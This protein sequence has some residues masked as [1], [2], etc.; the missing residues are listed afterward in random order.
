M[1]DHNDAKL[2]FLSEVIQ[3]ELF[4]KGQANIIIAPC[5]SGKTTAAVTKIAALASA[6]EKV[7]FL[8]DTTAGKQA[9]LTRQETAR[10]TQ[11]WLEEIKDEWWGELFSGNGIRVMSYHQL[12]YQLQKHPDFLK[13]IEVVVCDEMHNLIKFLNIERA[14]N[15]QSIQDGYGPEG[16]PCEIALAE[17][18]RISAKL[19]D[20]PLVVIITAT[21]NAVSKVLDS[22]NVPVEYFDYTEAAYSDRTGEVVYYDKLAEVLDKLDAQRAIIYVPTINGMKE[23]AKNADDGWRNICCLWGLHNVDHTMSDAQLKVRNT[24]LEIRRIPDDIDLLFINAAYETSINIDNEDF[25]TVIVHSSNPDVQTQVRER[26]RHDIDVLYLH[27]SEHEHVR[28]YFPEEYLNKFLTVKETRAIAEKMNLHNSKG[29][30]L[31]WPSV[32]DKLANDG[33]IIDYVKQHGV[34]GYIIRKRL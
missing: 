15:K 19:E 8:I 34:R 20:V 14:R 22:R 33:Y 13:N 2:P 18:C 26:L 4:Q 25:R 31:K 7:L 17:L 3:P 24:I 1:P 12:G 29:Q 6:N 11:A 32:C 5:H 16:N 28:H 9:L 10:F 21:I 30:L 27:D 23:A